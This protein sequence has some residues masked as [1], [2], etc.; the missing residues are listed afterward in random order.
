[1]VIKNKEEIMLNEAWETQQQ[2]NSIRRK[3]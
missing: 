2:L 1:M 3:C